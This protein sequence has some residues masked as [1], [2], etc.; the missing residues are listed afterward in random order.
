MIL[1]TH[2]KDVE[3]PMKLNVTTWVNKPLNAFFRYTEVCFYG[4]DAVPPYLKI[5]VIVDG[6]STVLDEND[7]PQDS[8]GAEVGKSYE[9]KVYEIEEEPYDEEEVELMRALSVKP[10]ETKTK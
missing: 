9:V 2:F 8:W 5:I 3:L 4:E 10:T 7:T 1:I 6:E